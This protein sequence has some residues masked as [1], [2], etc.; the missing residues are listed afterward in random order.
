MKISAERQNRN[1]GVGA[2]DLLIYSRLRLALSEYE[3][4]STV[5]S[6]GA[7][8][9]HRQL[10]NMSGRQIC[11]FIQNTFTKL[12][13]GRSKTICTTLLAQITQ[14]NYK[15]NSSN[16]SFIQAISIAPL[17]VHYYSEALPTQHEYYVGVSR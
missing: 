10:G 14:L 4:C 16:N 1:Y 17:Q 9:S 12:R 5:Q 11:D 8:T 15:Y 13:A 7:E 6:F 3:H 2:V